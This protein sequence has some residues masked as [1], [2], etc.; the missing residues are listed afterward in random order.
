MTGYMTRR[1]RK[2]IELTRGGSKKNYRLEYPIFCPNFNFNKKNDTFSLSNT[3]LIVF[4]SIRDVLGFF[5]R[6]SYNEIDVKKKLF[7][8]SPHSEVS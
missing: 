2:F 7:I 4:K 5:I 6:D 3:F 8:C 1:A